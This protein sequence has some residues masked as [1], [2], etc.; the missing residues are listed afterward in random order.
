MTQAIRAILG[1]ARATR[2]AAGRREA[3]ATRGRYTAPMAGR[4]KGEKVDADGVRP[5]AVALSRRL[6]RAI[7]E[8]VCELDHENPWQLLVA[9]ILSAQS[10]DRRVNLVTPALFEACPTPEALAE[11]PRERVEE[12]VKSTGFFR[13]K[14]KNIQGA[15]SLLVERHGGQVPADLDALVALPGVARKT[16]NLVMGFCFGRPTGIVVDTH[17][18]RVAR[19]LGL[20][21]EEDPVKVERDLCAAFP[22]SLWILTGQRFVLHGRYVCLARKPRC[23]HCALNE[24]CPS[25]EAAPAGTWTARAR[26]EDRLVASRGDVDEPGR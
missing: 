22:E 14:A 18:G 20:T 13:N 16:A 2:A 11:A 4:S 8:P 24:L 7:P 5:D 6:A 21:R 19:R 10:T 23:A 17:A 15:S 12:L 3:T 25:A 9:T 26:F 1:A